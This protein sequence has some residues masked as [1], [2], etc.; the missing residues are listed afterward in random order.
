MKSIVPSELKYT[1]G[2]TSDQIGFNMITAASGDYFADN[3]PPQGARI[4]KVVV[5]HGD[6]VDAIQASYGNTNMPRHGGGGGNASTINLDNDEYLVAVSGVSGD[7]FGRR[8][9]V[10]LYLISNKR[11]YGPYGTG[12]YSTNPKNFHLGAPPKQR[13]AA[14]NGRTAWHTSGESY[15][16]AIG[17]GL[18]HDAS[19]TVDSGTVA[20]STNAGEITASGSCAAVSTSSCGMAGSVDYSACGVVA[21]GSSACGAVAAGI[22]ACGAVAG[23][24]GVCGAVAVGAG[25]CGSDAAGVSG[26]ALTACGHDAAGMSACGAVASGTGVCGVV[27][28]GVGA[29]A[30]VVSAI[31]ACGADVSGVE[32][33]GAEASATE[34]CGADAGF[35]I[36]GAGICAANLGF[37]GAVLCV[38]LP[39]GGNW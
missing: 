21:A 14:F 10:T 37:C 4:T 2:G 38:A 33:C 24:Y 13:I 32:Y 29:C 27:A 22:G 23:H 28:G 8:H 31:G 34:I 7:Y 25:V 6:V 3:N 19:V 15:I 11:T 36:Q 9:I 39:I 18:I 1:Y 30:A 5:R 17:V 12:S 26:G 16:S 20:T 35:Q